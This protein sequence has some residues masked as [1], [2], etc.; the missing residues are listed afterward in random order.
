MTI[1]I[2]GLK[3]PPKPEDRDLVSFKIDVDGIVYDWQ[4]YLPQGID[5]HAFLTARTTQIEDRIRAKE[6]EWT[7]L[8]PKTR[9]VLDME[10]NPELDPD[11]GEPIVSDILKSEIVRPN[12][13]DAIERRRAL[14]P[15]IGDQLD[16]LW[17]GSS[18]PEYTRIRTEIQQIKTD[19]PKD[20]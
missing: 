4:F 15:T 3:T 19:N 1:T 10:G 6:A 17:K 12:I 13:P 8:T 5:Y 16:A 18:D 2:T 20:L 14:Y 9:P 7:A 11:T